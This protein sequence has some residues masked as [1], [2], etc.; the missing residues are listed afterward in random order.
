MLNFD[1]SFQPVISQF[2]NFI[3]QGHV[4]SNMHVA[5]T[6]LT[7]FKAHFPIPGK[8][9]SNAPLLQSFHGQHQ[10]KSNS[11]ARD[12]AKRE[13]LK[14]SDI[15]Y[16]PCLS[17]I[18][19]LWVC[20]LW[21]SHAQLLNAEPCHATAVL[22]H[23]WH[24]CSFFGNVSAWLQADCSPFSRATAGLVPRI[25]FCSC[26][27]SQWRYATPSCFVTYRQ[28]RCGSDSATRRTGILLCS[29]G[30]SAATAPW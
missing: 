5:R 29:N 1:I 6:L 7:H 9:R 23:Q 24:Q 22:T 16:N 4:L 25:V 2:L 12:F 28:K 14:L 8:M 10:Y 20:P 3:F 27:D 13:Q 30:M 11:K 26:N 15:L 19:Q 17:L 18:A 21:S